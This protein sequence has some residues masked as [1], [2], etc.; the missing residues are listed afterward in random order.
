MLVKVA[1]VAVFR[2]PAWHSTKHPHT[3]TGLPIESVITTLD[4]VPADTA[5]GQSSLAHGHKYSPPRQVPRGSSQSSLPRHGSGRE[6]QA[7]NLLYLKQTPL[8]LHKLLPRRGFEGITTVSIEIPSCSFLL[9]V[10]LCQSAPRHSSGV[11]PPP[12]PPQPSSSSR[13]TRDHEHTL[14]APL[15]WDLC[16]ITAS[17]RPSLAAEDS[18]D[19]PRRGSP[20]PAIPRLF[21]SHPA[22]T[23]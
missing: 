6:E 8:Q 1:E 5:Q 20:L 22:F 11:Q 15:E 14:C 16:H 2:T 18:P 4:T 13:P 9:G 19:P 21:L 17:H 7:A 23:N 3:R 12:G 10:L